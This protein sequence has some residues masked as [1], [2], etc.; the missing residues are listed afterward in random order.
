MIGTDKNQQDK[1]HGATAMNGQPFQLGDWLVEPELNRLTSAG[2][3]Q[4]IEPRLMKLLLMLAER[5]GIVA[6]KSDIV[7]TVWHGLSVTDE[8]LAKA[9]SKLRQILGDEPDNPRYIETIRKTGYR[10]VAPVKRDFDEPRRPGK[11]VALTGIISA[12]AALGL[13][14]FYATSMDFAGIDVAVA[15]LNALP[16]TSLPGRERD[17]NVSPD[18]EYVVY[19]AASGEGDQV[20]LHGIGRGTQ[21]RQLT[22]RGDN[23]APVFLPDGNS[24]AFLRREGA[25]CTVMQITLIDGAERVL[26]DCRGNGF[27]D[28]AMSPDGQSLAFNSRENDAGSH[29][30]TVFDIETGKRRALTRPPAEIW[31]DYDPQF[32]A[33]GASIVFARSI[34][35]GMQDIYIVDI[36][37]GRER[38]I[39]DE[40]R[41]VMGISLLGDRILYGTNRSGRY[42]IWSIDV[43]GETRYQF[44]ITSAGL[45]NPSVSPGGTTLVFEVLDR[46]IT[47]EAIDLNGTHNSESIL[48]LNADILHPD[49]SPA[50]DRTVFSANRSGFYEIWDADTS[51]GDLRRLTNFASGFTAHPKYSPDGRS[52]AFD[53]RPEAIARIYVMDR[54]G[55]NLVAISGEFTNAYAPT[56]SMDGR[57]LYYSVETDD[58]MQVWRTDVESGHSVQV[59]TAGGLF[60]REGVDGFL[61]HVRPNEDG[62][63]RIAPDKPSEVELMSPL[64]GIADWG[65]WVLRD[66]RI[67]YYDRERNAIRAFLLESREFL[68]L[69]N[70]DGNV[71]GADPAVAISAGDETAY[72]GIQSRFESDLEIVRFTTGE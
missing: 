21:D 26:G 10:L 6:M 40:G 18:G 44:A 7:D 32:T 67:V 5:P 57:N 37:T 22:R 61:Y 35:E 51:G 59:T 71:P 65:N 31:G 56:W 33:D 60:A 68:E 45:I 15:P 38:R 16:I 11:V 20:F 64:P 47:L 24:I 19:S 30:I 42:G 46:A 55:A 34:S 49:L 43:S 1:A 50:G 41:N 27:S 72:V 17:P 13:V 52:I 66:D 58:G 8:S 29:A 63:W 3:V 36:D 12:V 28:T 39:T 9:V 25:G 62:I 70:V 53:A 14:F 69:A 54:N 48:S 2:Q 23:R 4:Q